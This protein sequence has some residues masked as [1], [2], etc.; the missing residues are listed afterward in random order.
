MEARLERVLCA[1]PT[2]EFTGENGGC[3]GVAI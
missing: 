1:G 2:T 3:G